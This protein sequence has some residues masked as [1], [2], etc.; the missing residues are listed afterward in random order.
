V[1]RATEFF[2]A[3]EKKLIEA[4]I[5]EAEQKTAGEIVPVVATSSGRYD[6]GED[7]FG[8]VCA[9]ATLA[10]TWWFVQDVEVT[11]AEWAASHTIA[12]GLL[13][14]LAIVVL[15][16]L[17][18]AVVAT[19]VPALRLPFISRG[20]MEEEVE[21][22][23]AAAFQ[24]FRVRGTAAGTGILI[25]VSLYEHMVRVVGDDAVNARVTQADWDAVCGLAVDGLR[26]GRGAQGLASAIR[27]AGELLSRHFPLQADDRNEL[28]NE[29]HLLD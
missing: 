14:V 27:K 15:A 2:S 26:A 3:E 21:R 22:S 20:E 23:A 17:L 29:L 9:L 11:E 28:H 24:R 10:A 1:K 5:D 19:F 25:Y 13:P 18:G 6:R 12:L 7:L 4:A 8:L 16:F